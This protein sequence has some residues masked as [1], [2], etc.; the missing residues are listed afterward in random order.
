MMLFPYNDMFSHHDVASSST[1]DHISYLKVNGQ[2]I[3]YAHF[4][5]WKKDILEQQLHYVTKYLTNNHRNHIDEYIDTRFKSK[6]L[7]KFLHDQLSPTTFR[8][9]NWAE[10]YLQYV[11]FHCDSIH[12][13]ELIDY[14][15]AYG[16]DGPMIVDST[17]VYTN[18]L[19]HE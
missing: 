17:I 12:Q 9:D 18:R 14:T 6:A 16:A 10:W 15:I 1:M 5:Y 4:P 3:P 7:N 13:I 2:R 19:P 8:F 11:H